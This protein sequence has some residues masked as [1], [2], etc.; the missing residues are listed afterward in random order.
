MGR[1][2]EID[3]EVAD[4][5]TLCCLKDA[6]KYCLKEQEWYEADEEGRKNLEEKWGHPMWVHKDDY[7]DTMSKYIPSLKTLI[8]YFGGEHERC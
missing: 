4:R 7:A 6:L 2:L 5:I 8:V 3:F 1:G